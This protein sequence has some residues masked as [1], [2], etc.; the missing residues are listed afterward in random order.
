[1]T[2]FCP[3]CGSDSIETTKSKHM[4]PVIYG[5]F[6][7]YDEILEKC[8]VCG[9]S[10]DFSGVNDE[11]VDKALESAKKQSVINMLNFLSDKDIKMS[12][13]E[14]ALELPA[15]TVARW[16]GGDLSATTLA[17]L[18]IIRTYPWILEVA[19]A[20]YDE[21][22]AISRLVEEAAHAIQNV[23]KP[24]T[25]QAQVAI[26]TDKGKM[27]VHAELHFNAPNFQPKSIQPTLA[28]MAV[29]EGGS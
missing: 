16:K 13:M 11:Q 23:L 26:I 17:L 7:S 2:T 4:I 1:M 21:S 18:R 19:D 9:E 29:I 6:A 27:E 5:N 8:L 24:H 28:R 14:R 25:K 15:R 12:Y 22:V 3:A 20:H 10:G